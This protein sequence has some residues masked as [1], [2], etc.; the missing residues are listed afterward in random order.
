MLDRKNLIFDLGGVLLNI[1]PR[2]TADALAAMG[3]GKSL[4][5]DGLNLVNPMLRGLECGTVASDE[6]Y[7]AVA[8]TMNVEPSPEIVQS[9][10]EAWCAMLRDVP[11]EKLQ[12]LRT[13]RGQGYRIFLLS[14]TNA[15]HWEAIERIVASVE[16]RAL[17]EYFDGVY[18][19]FEM[20]CCKPDKMIFEKLLESEGLVAEDCIFFDDSRENCEA[21]A[22]LGI[23]AHQMTR[24]AAWPQWLIE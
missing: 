11:I 20:H 6:I 10:K 18:L 7:A 16:G 8:A 2:A 3:V 19:S 5:T 1:D 12:R 22:S 17:A 14:N 9:I 24:N 23:A 13:L 15:I 4:I 21:A